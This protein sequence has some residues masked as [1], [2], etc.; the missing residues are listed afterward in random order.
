MQHHV[1]A[2]HAAQDLLEARQ[3]LCEQIGQLIDPLE[4]NRLATALA[5]TKLKPDVSILKNE[6]QNI[7]HTQFCDVWLIAER[8]D[9]ETTRKI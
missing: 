8:Y 4:R 3:Y 9:K 5:F 6:I 1:N 7:L 2:I